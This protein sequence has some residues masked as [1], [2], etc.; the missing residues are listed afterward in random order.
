MHT[1]SNDNRTM[2]SFLIL[3]A[4]DQTN[5]SIF[6][7]PLK[8]PCFRKR[9]VKMNLNHEPVKCNAE[10]KSVRYAKNSGDCLGDGVESLD[11]M[12]SVF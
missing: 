8:L 12:A 4:M 1:K 7:G 5:S 11:V 10:I 2:Q 9:Y 3:N 6:S